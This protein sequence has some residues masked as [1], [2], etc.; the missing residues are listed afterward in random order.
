MKRRKG[1]STR[2]GNVGVR[3]G[4]GDGDQSKTSLAE[5]NTYAQPRPYGPSG[6]IGCRRPIR[7]HAYSGEAAWLMYCRGVMKS[8]RPAIFCPPVPVPD[9]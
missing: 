5:T 2:V 6:R 7:G 8:I 1:K 4:K 9:L 3:K